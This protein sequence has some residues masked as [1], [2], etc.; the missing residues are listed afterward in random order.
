MF[1]D[2][3]K[4]ASNTVQS[5]LGASLLYRKHGGD[6]VNGIRIILDK[7]KAF[8]DDYGVISGYS[9]EASFLKSEIETVNVQDEFVE[10]NGDTWRITGVVRETTAK[11]YVDV[12][13]I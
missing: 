4:R 5:V 7:N 12:V 8:K 11:W 9:V 13:K 3:I 2:V 10:L 6:T 1:N